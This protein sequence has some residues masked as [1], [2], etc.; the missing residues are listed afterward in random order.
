[1][2]TLRSESNVT[3]STRN[4]S[5]QHVITVNSEDQMTANFIYTLIVSSVELPLICLAVRAVYVLV[6]SRQAAPVFVINLLV[7][8]LIQIVSSL[9][10]DASLVLHWPLLHFGLYMFF[11]AI[12]TNLYFMT[13]IA[14]ERYILIAHSVWHRSH[15]SVKSLVYVSLT[16][17]FVSLILL[18][19]RWTLRYFFLLLLYIVSVVA[20]VIIAV[21]FARACRIL[22]QSSLKKQL[23][24]ASLLFVLLS[25]TFLILPYNIA[26]MLYVVFDIKNERFIHI[27]EKLLMITPLVD[28]FLY[29]FMRTDAP[30]SVKHCRPR[31]PTCQSTRCTSVDVLRDRV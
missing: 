22:F 31:P 25:Y 13:C 14:V 2:E 29:V 9:C 28:C 6:E 24:L 1:M 30:G 15:N 11:W 16:G 12:L 17:W 7:S 20:Y 26:L 5:D 4:A 27:S 3:V 19:F 21:C 18:L 10:I 23:V 8:D